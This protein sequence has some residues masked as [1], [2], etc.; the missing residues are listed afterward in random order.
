M[1]QIICK[2]GGLALLE[3]LR[4]TLSGVALFAPAAREL[5]ETAREAICNTTYGYCLDFLTFAACLP[6]AVRLFFGK[7]F[8]VC[9]RFAA[10]IAFLIF[11]RAALRCLRLPIVPLSISSLLNREQTLKKGTVP[12]QCQ[13]KV[14]CGYCLGLFPLPF[15]SS[16]LI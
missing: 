6:R 4:L 11:L 2:T 12:P 14:F 1:R 7:C 13:T 8:N 5:H 9:F 10:L 16:P 3:H 15:Q